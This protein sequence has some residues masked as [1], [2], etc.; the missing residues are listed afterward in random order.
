VAEKPPK[1]TPAPDDPD[2][3]FFDAH[4]DLA[5]DDKNFLKSKR[6]E[7]EY[8]DYLDEQKKKK[9]AGA[10]KSGLFGTRRR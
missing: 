1:D 3:E 2:K 8:L 4:P 5:E 10:P 7:R 9:A 6:V